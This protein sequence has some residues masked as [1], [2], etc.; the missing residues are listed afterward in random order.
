VGAAS[1]SGKSAAIGDGGE[2]RFAHVAS[3]SQE[4][5]EVEKKGKTPVRSVIEGDRKKSAKGKL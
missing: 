3:L 1:W 2:M 4:G 5:R